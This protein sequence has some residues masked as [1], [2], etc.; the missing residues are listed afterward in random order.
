[1]RESAISIVRSL[2]EAGFTAYFAGGC[3]RDSLLGQAPKDYDIATDASPDDVLSLYPRS[4][5]VGAHFGVVLVRLGGHHFDVAT[6]REDG[7]YEDGRRPASVA[8]STA[9]QDA[10]RRDFTLN[11]LFEDPIAGE[12]I[13]HVGGRADLENRVIRA[14]GTA[15]ERFEEDYLRMLRA[16][17]FATRF[18]FK[19][20]TDT[21]QALRENAPRISA[22][23]PERIRE[24]L[25][26]IWRSPNRLRG[27]DLLTESG[28]MAEILPEIL[29]LRGCEQPPQF[30]PEGDVFVHTRLMLSKLAPEAPL[31]VVLSV[32]L[33]DIAKPATQ[34]VD[35]DTGRIRFNGHDKLGAEMSVRIL[36]RLAYSNAVIDA[37]SGA[38]SR[39][40]QFINVQQMNRSTLKR[41]MANEQFEAEMELHRVDCLGS[42]GRLENYDFLRTKQE[43][44]A[45]EPII[46][47]PL[48]NGRDLIERGWSSGPELGKVLRLIQDLQLEG[49]LTNKEEALAWLEKQ[50]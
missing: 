1:M 41:F 31:E 21:W 17:R 7:D 28:L 16:I 20:E 2:Q 23:A 10:K 37:V 48:L 22:I 6:F 35:A 8:F 43:E 3:V 47:P 26:K 11:G 25:D 36:K 13:D 45:N 38:V 34:T 32:L 27:F 49:E 15:G 40:M 24:E 19:I 30:H 33:H 14:I 50:S 46:P 5:T 9:K 12:V 44:F 39:H 29:A 18:G 4:E 42:N